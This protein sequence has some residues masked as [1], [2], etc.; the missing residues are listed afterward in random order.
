MPADSTPR[1]IAGFSTAG[2]PLW[3]SST[4]RADARERDLLPAATFG[5]PQTTRCGS[6]PPY[7]D[8]REAQAVGVRVRLDA[9]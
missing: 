2:L 1:I 6:P 3:P 8:R 4:L 9:P 5:A 7:I